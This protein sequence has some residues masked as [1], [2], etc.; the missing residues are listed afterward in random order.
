MLSICMHTALKIE[1]A[2]EWKDNENTNVVK[3]LLLLYLHMMYCIT[4]KHENK[5]YSF[6]VYIKIRVEYIDDLGL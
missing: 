3:A 5:K 1:L 4:T 2:S 6:T